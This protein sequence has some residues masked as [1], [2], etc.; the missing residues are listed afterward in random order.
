MS[1]VV[2]EQHGVDR[3]SHAVRV[4]VALHASHAQMD[5]G[6]LLDLALLRAERVIIQVVQR[7]DRLARTVEL[8]EG[9]S[10]PGGESKQ[11]ANRRSIIGEV[12]SVRA[13]CR[14]SVPCVSLLT[15]SSWV[16]SAAPVVGV[17][18]PSTSIASEPAG[19]ISSTGRE[20]LGGRDEEQM[21]QHHPS[22]KRAAGAGGECTRPSWS[23]RS[24]HGG[25]APDPER[26]E[27]RSHTSQNA[28]R[29]LE[30][31]VERVVRLSCTQ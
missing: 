17:C 13:R 8:T 3:A 20:R 29:S 2:H 9:T 19:E 28:A 5:R 16:W 12:P 25:P 10:Q 24:H 11:E 1:V 22:R 21:E 27:E 7:H 18:W 15:R 26:T 14:L 23:L 31:R 30:V 4:V 6:I